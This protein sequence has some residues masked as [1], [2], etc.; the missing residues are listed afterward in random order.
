MIKVFYNAKE[1]LKYRNENENYLMIRYGF[2]NTYIVKDRF[3]ILAET[4][5]KNLFY[6]DEFNQDWKD[7]KYYS[8]DSLKDLI[9][10]YGKFTNFICLGNPEFE[11]ELTI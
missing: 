10:R 2:F 6:I 7:Y 5:S 9:K 8:I 4:E 1:Y 3:N 11:K